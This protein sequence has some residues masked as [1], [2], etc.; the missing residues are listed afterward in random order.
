[1]RL[2]GS[3]ELLQ[4][5]ADPSLQLSR[6][7]RSRASLDCMLLGDTIAGFYS[8]NSGCKRWTKKHCSLAS[9]L[10]FKRAP[11]QGLLR[12]PFRFALLGFLPAPSLRSRRK[13]KTHHCACCGPDGATG[14]SPVHPN[15]AISDNA[16]D[17][18]E[19][20][21]DT[22]TQL[23][24]QDPQLENKG[25]VEQMG[26]IIKFA[27]PALGIWL[28][29][30]IM[31]LIDTAVVGNSSSLELAA[32]GPGTVFCDQVGYLFM[33][34]SVATSNLIATSLAKQDKD[35]AAHH[36]SRLLFVGLVC[37][38]C[39]LI[40]TGVF[41]PMLLKA[42]VG[43]QNESLVP[44]A[45]SYVQIRGLAWPAVL[46]GLVAQ[47]A[48]LG[49][50][51]AWGPLKVLA[52]ASFLNFSGDILL[53]TCLGYGIAGAA[54]A[55]MFSQCIGGALMLRSLKTKGYNPLAL[56]IPSLEQLS[57]M[58]KLAAPVLLTIF[59]KVCFFSLVTYMSTALG[60]VTLAAHQVMV[61]L[62]ATC[63]VSAEPL[64]QTA[65][66]FM[67]ALI[68]G[69]RRNVKKAQ[70]LLRSL[71]VIGAF[72][73]LFLGTLGICFPWLFPHFFTHDTAV[74]IQMRAI[75]LPFL[76]SLLVTPPLLALEGTLLAGRDLKFLS[77]YMV[78][79]VVA[80][81]S[82]LMVCKRMAS[83][84]E[85]IWWTVGFFQTIR[86]IMA[87]NR[88]TSRNSIIRDLNQDECSL[89]HWKS[90]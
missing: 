74:I 25:L 73:G 20:S 37:G 26:D 80:C 66:A 43:P 89:L 69:A 36:L 16:L 67:P 76:W 64:A 47:S 65:Q 11:I 59:S 4:H 3:R 61:G 30:P 68:Q 49:M 10:D 51:D 48:S 45:C 50:Q 31:S 41:S 1:M 60:A 46:V 75:T 33:F 78:A 81:S 52:V 44:A 2:N 23:P 28:S 35:G 6:S 21:C 24:D 53:C 7:A 84:L 58:V 55:T 54:W 79:C 70:M 86:F 39:M 29:G 40:L 17:A 71:M 19:P 22:N 85:G 63:S 38:I 90:S 82:F 83:G 32:L 18:L 87:L 5:S 13:H 15:S 56:R 62:F 9:A 57:F 88:L 8:S 27:G 42:F 72:S 34:L 14:T 77:L 12:V